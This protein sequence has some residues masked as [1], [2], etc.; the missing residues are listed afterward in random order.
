MVDDD[1]WRG[2]SDAD[3]LIRAEEIKADPDRHER[4]K[5]HL[6]MRHRAIKKAAGA[7][8]PSPAEEAVA[9]GYRVLKG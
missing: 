5:G 4:A 9:K 3:A 6:R 7:P 8:G 2:Q 1:D